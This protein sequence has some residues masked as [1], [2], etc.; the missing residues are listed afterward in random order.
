MLEVVIKSEVGQ[1]AVWLL[2]TP[3]EDLCNGDDDKI[4]TNFISRYYIFINSCTQLLTN[5]PLAR[6]QYLLS[7]NPYLRI[8]M[9]LALLYVMGLAT[10][11]SI[12]LGPSHPSPSI[13]Q[14]TYSYLTH[15]LNIFHL[16]FSIHKTIRWIS[17]TMFQC[18]T[19]IQLITPKVS[20]AALYF[21]VC[22]K[23]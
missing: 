15:I 12:Q 10:A 1:S 7:P 14:L 8:S 19:I 20:A 16:T 2:N 5:I 22:C 18:P 11:M 6:N 13:I 17:K 23:D 21:K 3:M 9:F 4:Y